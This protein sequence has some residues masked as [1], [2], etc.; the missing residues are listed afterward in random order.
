MN[1]RIT[2]LEPPY[3]EPVQAALDRIMPAGVPPTRYRASEICDSFVSRSRFC[4]V[5]RIALS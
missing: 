1:T 5:V 2:P 4:W 3:P